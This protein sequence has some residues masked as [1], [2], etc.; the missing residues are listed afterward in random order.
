MGQGHSRNIMKT[1]RIFCCC[2]CCCCC[3]CDAM[4]CDARDRKMADGHCKF[5]SASGWEVAYQ[6]TTKKARK[7]EIQRD[8]ERE[9]ETET[10]QTQT[11][12]HAQLGRQAT[13]I[14]MWFSFHWHRR[15][16]LLPLTIEK[17]SS[18]VVAAA[19]N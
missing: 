10:T 9:R 1:K 4:R 19:A 14:V 15:L 18:A 12:S 16:T 13:N 6:E 3:C 11:Q 2:C 7:R 5:S 17:A 8:R